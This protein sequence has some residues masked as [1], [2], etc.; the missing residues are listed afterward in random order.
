MQIFQNPTSMPSCVL[1]LGMFDGVHRGHQE[2][3]LR[4]LSIARERQLPLTVCTFEPHPLAVLCPDRAPK[5]LTTQTERARLMASYG[6]DNLC[7]HSF[8]RQLAGLSPESFI[9]MICAVYHPV[10]VVCG[11]NYTFGKAGQGKGELLRQRGKE[12]G[13]DTVIVREVILDGATVSSTRIREEL[14]QG[15]IQE[16][17]KLLGHEWTLCGRVVDGKHVGRRLGFPT[18]NVSIRFNK[19]L[20]AYGV[21]AC[22]LTRRNGQSYQAVVNVGRH[23]TLPEGKVTVEANVLHSS[24]DLYGERVRLTMMKHLRGEIKFDSVELLREQIAMD[25]KNAEAYFSS[26]R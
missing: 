1:V 11:F 26:L 24:L 14:A 21:Y 10:C 16:V 8:T 6:V 18:A 5:R 12:F 25:V 2:L 3:L 4:G 19:A 22:Y 17:S 9:Q 15:H 13:F 7:V 23:P 20:P